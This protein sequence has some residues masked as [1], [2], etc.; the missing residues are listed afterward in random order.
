VEMSCGED[1]PVG[2]VGEGGVR[3]AQPEVNPL[4]TPQLVY[5]PRATAGQVR[6]A[7]RAGLLEGFPKGLARIW[8]VKSVAP[9]WRRTP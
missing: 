1:Q 3:I 4:I 9:T 8:L 7:N 5:N 2:P 6:R